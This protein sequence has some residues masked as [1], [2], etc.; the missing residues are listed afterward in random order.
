MADKKRIL[1]VH[2]FCTK[3]LFIGVEKPVD[4]EENI[5]KYKLIFICISILRYMNYI[6]YANEHCLG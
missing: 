2:K 4:Y 3:L 5:Y 1:T 6:K